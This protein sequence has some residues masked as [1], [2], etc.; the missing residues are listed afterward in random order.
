MTNQPPVKHWS[1]HLGDHKK[2][3]NLEG[4]CHPQVLLTHAHQPRIGAHD[5]AAI[6][7]EVTC[8]PIGSGFEVALMASQVNQRENLGR[9]G[10]VV[11]AGVGAKGC[12]VQ[13]AAVCVEL[14]RGCIFPYSSKE[15]TCMMGGKLWGKVT[16]K[17]SVAICSHAKQTRQQH[18]QRLLNVRRGCAAQWKKCVR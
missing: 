11:T 14:C 7:R 16:A 17:T 1:T 18:E 5:Q 10:D 4:Q 15:G 8:K 9:S 13:N 12:V 2:D 6:V 3:R